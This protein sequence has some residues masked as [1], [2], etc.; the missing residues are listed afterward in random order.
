MPK[1]SMGKTGSAPIKKMG[2]TASGRHGDDPNL[3]VKGGDTVR[4]LG[5]R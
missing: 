5:P 2:H 1:Q 3:K 4:D